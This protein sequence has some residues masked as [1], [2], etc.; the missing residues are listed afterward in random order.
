[1]AGY[2]ALRLTNGHCNYL[3]LQLHDWELNMMQTIFMNILFH[4]R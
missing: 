1:M 2:K 4:C 3:T